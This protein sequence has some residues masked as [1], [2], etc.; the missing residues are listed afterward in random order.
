MA[1]LSASSRVQ[2][3]SGS[4][5]SDFLEACPLGETALHTFVGLAIGLILGAASFKA[6]SLYS[7]RRRSVMYA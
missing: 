6:I 4:S 7:K 3:R 5:D 2:H 1:T